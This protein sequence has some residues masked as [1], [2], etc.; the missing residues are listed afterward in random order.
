MY[1]KN[2]YIFLIFINIGHFLITLIFNTYIVKRK[3]LYDNY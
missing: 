1:L 2:P 3:R